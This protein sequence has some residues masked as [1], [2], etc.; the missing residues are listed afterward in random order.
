MTKQQELEQKIK[1]LKLLKL[2]ILKEQKYRFYTP[3]GKCEE[4]IKA[5]GGGNFFVILFSAANGVGKTCASANI[6]AHILFGKDSDNKFFDLPLFKNW[7]FKKVGRIVSTPRNVENNIVP[8]LKSW[9]P[10]NRYEAKKGNKSFDSVWKTDNGHSFDIMTYEQDP[11]E[12][13]GASL[14]WAWFDEPPTEAI[15]KATVARMRM[16]G[17]IFISETPLT[18][19]AWLYDYV[20]ANINNDLGKLGLSK[21]IEADV[22]SACID[23]GIRGHLEHSQIEKLVASYS[24][25][26]KQARVYG[27]FQ[28]LAGLRF[29]QFSR[30]I[31]VIKPFP[32]TFNDFT[33]YHA[34]DTHPRH[35]DAGIWIAVDRQGNKFICNELSI[36]AVT[37]ELASRIKSINSQYRM[38]PRLLIE[39]AAY[40]KDQHTDEISL[41]EKLTKYGLNYEPATKERSASDRRIEEALSYQKIQMYDQEEFVKK[42]ELYIFDNLPV[43]LYEIEHYRWDEWSGKAADKH[44]QMEKTI[45]KDDHMIECIGRI[46]IQEPRFTVPRVNSIGDPLSYPQPIKQHSFDPYN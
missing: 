28:H 33:V 46:L 22:E 21:Y 24:E 34:L 40:N 3:N 18:G 36:K 23:H 10:A 30:N 8:A 43:T 32:I 26:D 37:P 14:G 17:I 42:P 9:L 20:V 12:F 16:G 6:V 11:G 4:Y 39:P 29:K 25:E 31:H 38:N 44:N 1:E 35:P 7:P 13:E 19:S 15:F 27:K 2:K 5:I 41:A 45:D